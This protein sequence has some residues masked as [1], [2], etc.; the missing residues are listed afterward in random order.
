MKLRYGLVVLWIAVVLGIYYWIHKP[1]LPWHTAAL[2]GI[3]LDG[4]AAF[5]FVVVGGGLGRLAL[6]F[7]PIEQSTIEQRSSEAL[8][9]LGILSLL[10]FIVGLVNLSQASMAILMLVLVVTCFRP[11]LKSAGDWLAWRPNLNFMWGRLMLAF[12]GINLLIIFMMAVLPPTKFDALTYHL[13]GPKLA[14]QEGRFTALPDNHF[15]GFPQ[16]VNTLYAG[17]IALLGGRLTSAAVL[18]GIMGTLMLI[19]MIGFGTRRFTPFVG[20][21]SA[22]VIITATSIWLQFAWPYVDLAHAAYGWLTFAMLDNWRRVRTINPLLLAGIAAGL[23]MSSKYNALAVGVSAACYITVYSAQ[24]PIRWIRFGLLFG[25]AAVLV[26]LPLLIR[27]YV[28][29]ENPVYPL[30]FNTA[31]W[32]DLKSEWYF[33][34]QGTVIQERWWQYALI[35]LM[36]TFMGVEGAAGFSAT[37]GPLF[38]LLTPILLLTW[39]RLEE[40]QQQALLGM[41]VFVL[42]F[43]AVW[44]LTSVRFSP[45]R[46]VLGMYPIMAFLA[47]A[48]LDSMN[49][50]PT[51]PLNIA[52]MM[53]V[54]VLLVMV[55]TLFAHITGTR[56]R[57]IDGI[58]YFGTTVESH[59]LERRTLEYW[60]GIIDEEQY[61]EES[62]GFSYAAIDQL[63]ELS[64]D[65]VVLFLWETR[66]LYCD[67]TDITCI[68]DTILLRWWHDRRLTDGSVD[69]VLELW[70]ERGVTHVLVWHTGREFEFAETPALTA[71]DEAVWAEMQAR[72]PVVWEIVDDYTLYRLPEE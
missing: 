14:V 31:D 56:P 35:F 42:F 59:F 58:T 2:A 70:R 10:I 44:I 12:I 51:K 48:A 23:A 52:W 43:H 1:I 46:H 16:L 68:E 67:E 60:F 20:W 61:L 45:T 19:H 49:R 39:R 8:V 34:D 28:F 30:L 50:L 62:L 25:I 47:A 32:D 55:F 18:H 64:D 9:G 3:F 5:L 6:S 13:V 4:A 11:I 37:I 21:L 69:A 71:E 26:L 33:G 65:A 7:I 36:P 27:N 15:F 41:I 66:S 53:R 17:Q 57:D 38:V 22:V 40:S 24:Q 72:L 29:Y 63:N 54:A